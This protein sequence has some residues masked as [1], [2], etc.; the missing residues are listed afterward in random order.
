MPST[1]VGIVYSKSQGIIR[2]TID[3]RQRTIP[4]PDRPGESLRIWDKE[5]ARDTHLLPHWAGM[6]RGEAWEEIPVEVYDTFRVPL[7][8]HRYLGLKGIPAITDRYCVVSPDGYVK[9]VVCADPSCGDTHPDGRLIHDLKA[10]VGWRYI[11]GIF[12]SPDI[13]TLVVF[14]KHNRR[15]KP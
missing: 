4:H 1:K 10:V 7:D 5:F 6:A 2:R 12:V 11:K 14:I 3:A 9:A 15:M 8:A 13:K